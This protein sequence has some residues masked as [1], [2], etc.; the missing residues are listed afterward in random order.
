MIIA[1][2]LKTKPMNGWKVILNTD[3]TSKFGIRLNIKGGVRVNVH[4]KMVCL[5]IMCAFN[6]KYLLTYVLK[7]N[8]LGMMKKTMHSGNSR[9][10]AFPP[11]MLAYI[12]KQRQ[13]KYMISPQSL[14]KLELQSTHTQ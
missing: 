7:S 13:A 2:W 10:D 12:K 8:N 4:L 5:R 3:K 6:S 14:W 1:H 9:E 11:E